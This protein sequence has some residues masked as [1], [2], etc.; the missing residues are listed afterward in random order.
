MIISTPN[1]HFFLPASE[2]Q[3]GNTKQFGSYTSK[4]LFEYRTGT[5][6]ITAYH[7]SQ[8][9]FC[10][11]VKSYASSSLYLYDSRTRLFQHVYTGRPNSHCIVSALN[12][13][14]FVVEENRYIAYSMHVKSPIDLYQHPLLQGKVERIIHFDPVER[15]IVIQAV[16]SWDH[17]QLIVLKF[18]PESN[19]LME[20]YSG[21]KHSLYTSTNLIFHNRYFT[22]NRFTFSVKGRNRVTLVRTWRL[23]CQISSYIYCSPRI[24]FHIRLRKYDCFSLISCKLIKRLRFDDAFPLLVSLVSSKG[25]Q[26]ISTPSEVEDI[27]GLTDVFYEFLESV[28]I[29]SKTKRFLLVYTAHLLNT[30]T[31]MLNVF[32]TDGALIPT[33]K[34]LILL[35]KRGTSIRFSRIKDEKSLQSIEMKEQHLAEYNDKILDVECSSDKFEFQLTKDSILN[36]FNLDL[37]VLNRLFDGEKKEDIMQGTLIKNG[38][39]DIDSHFLRRRFLMRYEESLLHHLRSK[40]NPLTESYHTYFTILQQKTYAVIALK[41]M[42]DDFFQCIVYELLQG[43]SIKESMLRLGNIICNLENHIIID[44]KVSCLNNSTKDPIV[45]VGL[46]AVKGKPKGYYNLLWIGFLESSYH[47]TIPLPLT[48]KE[49]VRLSILNDEHLFIYEK[50]LGKYLSISINELF[51]S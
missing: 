19:Q 50:G 45:F 35:Q 41:T 2:S 9:E 49:F 34:G 17:G 22:V 21:C 3:G 8:H 48:G 44:L 11:W 47:R 43:E 39:A 14:F 33:T 13:T 7:L 40:E 46:L 4:K 27:Y 10:I 12:K 25:I 30:T 23:S 5:P 32:P 31:E 16:F 15:W 38:V 24:S 51:Q 28:V 26:G 42:I 18:D 29:F 1:I 20:Y 6:T 36:S 37:V